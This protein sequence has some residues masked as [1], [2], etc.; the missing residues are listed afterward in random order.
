MGDLENGRQVP[1][2]Y[3]LNGSGDHHEGLIRLEIWPR[4]VGGRGEERIE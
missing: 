2:S 3:P 4:I 1:V